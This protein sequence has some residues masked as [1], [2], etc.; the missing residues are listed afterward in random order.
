MSLIKSPSKIYFRALTNSLTTESSSAKV[1]SMNK[2]EYS[3]TKNDKGRNV[4]EISVSSRNTT[5][6]DLDSLDK[7]YEILMSSSIRER[8]QG[9]FTSSNSF[10]IT[11]PHYDT[12]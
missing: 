6:E 7:L 5:K 12:N 8:G 11:I 4:V 2:I 1:Y 10:K 3:I 9:G